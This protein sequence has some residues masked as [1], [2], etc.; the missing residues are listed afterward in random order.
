MKE[1]EC[2]VVIRMKKKRVTHVSVVTCTGVYNPV[3]V[4]VPFGQPFVVPIATAQ[5]FVNVH[6]RVS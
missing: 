1:H 6:I 3:T 5:G 2:S 4:S